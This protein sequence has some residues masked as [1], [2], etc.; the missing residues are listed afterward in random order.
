MLMVY[1]VKTFYIR[2]LFMAEMWEFIKTFY[3]RCFSMAGIWND[4]EPQCNSQLEGSNQELKTDVMEVT[5]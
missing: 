4:M 2:C 5:S 3:L 1:N